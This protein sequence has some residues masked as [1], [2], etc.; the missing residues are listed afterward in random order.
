MEAH[1]RTSFSPSDYLTR[2]PAHVSALRDCPNERLLP[3]R[4]HACMDQRSI[5]LAHGSLLPRFVS[6]CICRKDRT[7]RILSIVVFWVVTPCGHGGTNVSVEHTAPIF[8]TEVG[9]VGLYNVSE[10]QTASNFVAED[11]GS[12]FHHN[13]GTPP[14]PFP[15]SALKMKALCSTN[16]LVPTDMSTRHDYPEDYHQHLHR[17]DYIKSH[18]TFDKLK[19]RKLS[20]MS[21]DYEC[22][23]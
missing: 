17:L 4:P 10:E 19:I 21:L 16:T 18:K 6:R 5:H 2:G 12:I 9:H 22:C 3:A 7:I 15:T 14:P 1:S 11:V 23:H 13:T 20:S 8:R